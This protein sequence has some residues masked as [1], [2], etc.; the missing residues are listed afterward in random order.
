MKWK[1]QARKVKKPN[2]S[3]SQL[4]DKEPKHFQGRRYI[5]YVSWLYIDYVNEVFATAMR[6]K[7]N[8]FT[9]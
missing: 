5:L 9:P 4:F 2:A 3:V 6:N 8:S 7:S 1:L